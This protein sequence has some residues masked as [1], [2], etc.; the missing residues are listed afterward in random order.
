ME[1]TEKKV[2]IKTLTW[3]HKGFGNFEAIFHDKKLISFKACEVGNLFA[4]HSIDIEFLKCLKITIE[5]ILK[6]IEPS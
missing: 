5:D 3:D 1:T 2:E 6:E 4:I